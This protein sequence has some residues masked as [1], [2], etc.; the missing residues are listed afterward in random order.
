MHIGSEYDFLFDS[1]GGYIRIPI[2]GHIPLCAGARRVIE[3]PDFVRI[4]RI[5]QL[6]F[7]YMVFPGALHSRFEHSI[8]TYHLSRRMLFSLI[9]NPANRNG[10]APEITPQEGRVF[11]A[12][13]LLHDIGHYPYA[14]LMEQLPLQ[15]H[16]ERAQSY[17]LESRKPGSLYAVLRD[18]WR[19]DPEEVAETIASKRP[20]HLPSRML[21]G[22]LDPDKMDYLMRDAAACGVPYGHIDVERLIESLVPDFQDGRRRLG[23]SEKGIAPLESLFFSKYMMFRNVYWHHTVRIAGSMFLRFVQDALEEGTVSPNAFYGS[24]DETLF[25]SLLFAA[26]QVES[27]PLL[28]ALQRRDLF[29]RALVFYPEYGMGDDLFRLSGEDLDRVQRLYFQPG[30][31]RKKE[32]ALCR[33]LSRETGSPLQGWEVLIDV[34]QVTSVF[35]LEDFREMHVLVPSPL[36]KSS[37]RF[38]PFDE[39]FSQF[40]PDFARQFEQFSRR[41]QVVCRADLRPA[42][43]RVWQDVSAILK[44]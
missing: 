1:S 36:D 44:A 25:D 5:R 17:L 8:G 29:K 26:P 7:V 39:Q 13:A 9:A 38:L 28:A 37:L 31:R 41:V 33:I 42:L 10:S 30:L 23:I 32:E 15:S 19:V 4:Q 27:A 3:H 18:E 24:A 22:T 11:L 6:S 20:G 34:P 35:D 12:S 40:T 21:S 16:E 14:H 43:C 2:W